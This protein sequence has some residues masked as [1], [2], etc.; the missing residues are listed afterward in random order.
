MTKVPH[1]GHGTAEMDWNLVNSCRFRSD[2]RAKGERTV[3]S[4]KLVPLSYFNSGTRAKVEINVGI[5][6][7]SPENV[8][9]PPNRP[10]YTLDDGTIIKKDVWR[11]QQEIH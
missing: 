5:P 6:M 8:S 9:P 1:D 11:F 10:A 3:Q 7:T 4:G 2:S